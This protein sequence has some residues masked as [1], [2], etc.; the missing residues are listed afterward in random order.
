MVAFLYSLL[1]TSI[2]LV[3][4]AW[5]LGYVEADFDGEGA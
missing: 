4:E 2:H 5:M 1:K 3:L